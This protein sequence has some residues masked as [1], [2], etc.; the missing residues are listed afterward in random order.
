[1]KVQF[2]SYAAC[3]GDWFSQASDGT[4]F[5]EQINASN[6][7]LVHLQSNHRIA[8]VTD[9][10]SN[11]ILLGERGHGLLSP[12]LRDS[13]HWWAGVSR[14]MFTTQWP[15][16]PQKKLS[17]GTAAIGPI[18]A[19]IFFLSAS[20]FH[21][22]GGNFAFADGSV[23]FLKDTIESWPLDPATGNPTSL[24]SDANGVYFV[25]PGAPVG[26]YQK[27]STRAGAR[28]SGVTT[29]TKPG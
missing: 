11:T 28:L 10:T 4:A 18:S 6:N 5:Y 23:H 8:D 2:S 26:L 27:L 3:T 12:D 1:M 16:N 19:T 29:E 17:D 13:W 21:P 22:N 7:G 9:G 20:S 15:L 14:T 24:A 25:T